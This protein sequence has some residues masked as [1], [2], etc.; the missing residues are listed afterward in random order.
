MN[1]KQLKE[2]TSKLDR[3]YEIIDNAKKKIA[4]YEN[5]IMEA[6]NITW[7]NGEPCTCEPKIIKVTPK[8]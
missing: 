7:C 3:Q 5:I 4:L 1:D 2:L 8:L 6:D